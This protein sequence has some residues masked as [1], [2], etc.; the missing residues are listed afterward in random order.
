MTARWP[1]SFEPIARQIS[2]R[3]GRR[4]A[5][6]QAD[7]AGGGCINQ[8]WAI[9]GAGQ[10]FFVK[11]NRADRLPMFQGEYDG[12]EALFAARAVRVPE[13]VCCGDDGDR[14]WLVV[15]YLELGTAED[16]GRLGEQLA[17]Q[18]RRRGAA[19]GWHRDNTIGSTPQPNP[20]LAHWVQFLRGARLGFQLQLAIERGYGS[21][22][23]DRGARLLE[24]LDAFFAGYDPAPSLLHGDLWSG[25][26][27]FLGHGE[28][29]IFD[30]AVYFGDREADL[31]M[32]ELFGGFGGG[33][34][35]AYSAAWPLEAG[36]AIRKRLYNLYHL[37]NHLNLFGAG[38]LARCRS[39]I[40]WLLA[41]A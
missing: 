37:L 17:V 3:T 2:H 22:L 39:E 41:Q 40:D 1:A 29:V 27:G 14:A 5:I 9:R 16:W 21:S 34:H 32:T 11:L 25:N 28:P 30:P 12:L 36:Y 18:H 23:A 24:A 4:F 6:E 31:A 7:A 35:A 19:F 33:F 13:P 38:Y 8:C 20:R 26:A 15:E 10:R